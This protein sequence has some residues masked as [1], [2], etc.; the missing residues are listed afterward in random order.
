MKIYLISLS[1]TI[2]F[3]SGCAKNSSGDSSSTEDN[4]TTIEAGSEMTV[5]SGD[6]IT[7]D[8]N[9]TEIVVS[10]HLNNEKSVKVIKGS[11]SLISG[12]YNIVK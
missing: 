6:S 7:P 1:L 3:F 8:T 9:D 12:N 2:L 4:V 11:V 10:H 5:K